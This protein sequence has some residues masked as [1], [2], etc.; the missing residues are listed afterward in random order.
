MGRLR[1]LHEDEVHRA[2]GR[3]EVRDDPQDR[4]VVQPVPMEVEQLAGRVRSWVALQA[5]RSCPTR[6]AEWKVEPLVSSARS[7]STTS[8]QPSRVS[9]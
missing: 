5:S 6:P 4:P 7:H 9:Q 2:H 8:P 3:D 1:G